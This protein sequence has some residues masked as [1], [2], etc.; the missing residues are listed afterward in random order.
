MS[1]GTIGKRMLMAQSRPVLEPWLMQNDITWEDVQP[2]LALLTLES[3]KLAHADPAKFLDELLHRVCGSQIA[4]KVATAQL[5]PHLTPVLAELGLRF[6]EIQPALELLGSCEQ[7]RAA[8]RDPRGFL[9]RFVLDS[10]VE[11]VARQVAH[12]SILTA[13][14]STGVVTR[15]GSKSRSTQ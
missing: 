15:F 3:L 2:I 7:V 1:G 14:G 6:E 8:V 13:A 12:P 4:I 9:K 11:D 5:R 10:S